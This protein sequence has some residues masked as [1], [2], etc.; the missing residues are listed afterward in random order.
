MFEKIHEPTQLEEVILWASIA[1]SFAL[2][3]LPY[4]NI[5][6]KPLPAV[7]FKGQSSAFHNFILA[8]NFA[9]FGSFVAISLRGIYPR[10]AR[11]CLVVAIISLATGICI[12]P[13]L[14]LPRIF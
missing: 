2:V 9:L 12:P 11:C 10:I 3:L 7:I 1:I 14:I 4:E 5:N 8:L 13:W 6:G